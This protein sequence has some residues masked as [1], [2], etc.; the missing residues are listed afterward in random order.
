MV[1][2]SP[3]HRRE[4]GHRFGSNQDLLAANLPWFW[5]VYAKSCVK[6]IGTAV[7]SYSYTFTASSPIFLPT[8]A[9]VAFAL[10]QRCWRL[11]A[12][13]N[14]RALDSPGNM[15]PLPVLPRWPHARLVLRRVEVKDAVERRAEL[16]TLG[17]WLLHGFFARH[18]RGQC[19]WSAKRRERSCCRAGPCIS[20][21][22]AGLEN[23]LQMS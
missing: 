6:T 22:V 4:T 21:M 17:A 1:F 15:R 16:V 11:L 10:G 7:K 23:T 9:P 8:S 5:G 12:R 14:P 2:A 19:F 18:I 3:P 13:C 20:S